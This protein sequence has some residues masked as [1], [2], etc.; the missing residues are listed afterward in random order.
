MR[1]ARNAPGIAL[2][3]RGPA[4]THE[5]SAPNVHRSPDVSG[6]IKSSGRAY[7]PSI[8]DKI[9]R[10]GDRDGHQ[11]FL[12]PEG[13]PT[14]S[15]STASR[16]AAGR[17]A[18]PPSWRRIPGLERVRMVRPGL[19]DRIRPV[20]PANSIPTLQTRRLPGLFLAGQIQRTQRL[21]TRPAAQGLV[22]GL[23]R[24]IG[25]PAARRNRRS[26]APTAISAVMIDDL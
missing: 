1:R 6:Q 18:A 16:L 26:I 17:G 24:G 20:I 8:E 22:A 3:H 2:H 25:P 4:A 23:K 15:S 19:C 5:V 14:D 11:I 21:R 9:V 10:F 13:P 7:C 12:E